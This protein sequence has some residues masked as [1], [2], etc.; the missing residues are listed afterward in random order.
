MLRGVSLAL[1]G[2]MGLFA[3]CGGD[4]GETPGA[5]G[6]GGVDAGGGSAGADAASGGNAGSTTGGSGGT[7]PQDAGQDAHVS[8]R[9]PYDEN[10]DKRSSCGFAPGDT[11]IKT[12]GPKVP[13]GD[14]LP[15]EHIVVLMQENRSFDH[16]FSELPA[17]G[18]TDVDVAT[19]ADFN[20]D[21]DQNPPAKIHR[22]HET[23]YCTFDTNHEWAGVHLQYDNGAMDGF[24]STNNPGGAR[25]MG[26]YDATDLPYYYWLAK[27]F[28]IS[29]RHFSSLLGPTWPNRFFFFG[30]TA[31]GN[32]KTGDV[33]VLVDDKYKTS[34]KILDLMQ[35]AGKTW[36]IYKD[37]TTSFAIVFKPT[38]LSYLGSS[39]ASFEA[40]VDANKLPNLAIIDPDFSGAGQNDEHPPANIQ[41]GQQFVARILNK[42]MSNPVVWKKTVFFLIYD[43][44]GGYYDHV[45]PPKACKPDSY[46]PPDF[47]FD[48]LG[49]RTPVVVASPWTK[50]GYVSHLDTDLTSVTRF[51]EN[52]FNLPA[53]TYRDANAWPMLDMF[54]F[55]NESFA[56]P[57]S[58][59]PSAAPDPT[60][61]KWCAENSP[62]TGMP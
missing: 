46:A 22:F 13:H 60:G 1:C 28:A 59:A 40:D 36:K 20:Y 61:E 56:T 11:T 6:A 24:V 33:G 38:S 30:A 25:A 26:Y 19:N 53:M 35:Q 57:P 12:I 15:F 49:I 10:A 29:D 44:H 23:R 42:L 37:G 2:L 39:I 8:T 21:P 16:Y 41:H 4:D 9:P 5:A 14:A 48:R 54:D 62:G 52:R 50:P 7:T 32:T 58:G 27:T 43:E 17:Y 55:D 34:T 31:W 18:V 47:E 3:A 45:P 51:I